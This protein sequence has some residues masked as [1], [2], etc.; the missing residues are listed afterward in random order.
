MTGKWTKLKNHFYGEICENYLLTYRD[1]YAVC[2]VEAVSKERKTY[3]SGKDSEL[4]C[5]VHRYVLVHTIAIAL[6]LLW[7][8]DKNRHITAIYK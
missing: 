1:R 2:S 4:S 8:P 7:L 3:G 5:L 6:A